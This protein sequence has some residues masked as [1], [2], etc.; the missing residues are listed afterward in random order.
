MVFLRYTVNTVQVK[1]F[2]QWGGA[3]GGVG[4]RG[5]VRTLYYMTITKRKT[6]SDTEPKKR[7]LKVIFVYFFIFV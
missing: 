3:V 4:G 5:A 1:D 6:F 7:V 2:R